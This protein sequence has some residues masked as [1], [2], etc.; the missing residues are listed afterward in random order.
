MT[1]YRSRRGRK[2]HPRR[3]IVFSELNPDLKPEQIARIVTQAGLEQA[4]REK[5]AQ[6]ER[7]AAAEADHA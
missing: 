4:R 3:V 5:E 2:V 6:A 7:Q 1:T